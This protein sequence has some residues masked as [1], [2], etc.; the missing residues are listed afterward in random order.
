[1]LGHLVYWQFIQS[2]RRTSGDL[3]R[4]DRW[5]QVSTRKSTDFA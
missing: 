2:D 5:R 4:R 1:M 3:D